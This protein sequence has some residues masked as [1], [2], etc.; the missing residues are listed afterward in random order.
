MNL[1]EFLISPQ[2]TARRE[3]PHINIVMSSR[4]RLARNIRGAAFPGWAKKADRVKSYEIIRPAVEAMQ[5]M[6][7]GFSEAIDSLSSLDKQLLVERHLISR[8]QAAKNAGSGLVLNKD[9]SLCVM[10]NEE[11]HLRMQSLRP[12]LQL[13]EAWTAISGVSMIS[14]DST[15]AFNVCLQWF[16]IQKKNRLAIAVV[17]QSVRHPHKLRPCPRCGIGTDGDRV[18]EKLQHLVL[19]L[20]CYKKP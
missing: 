4:V 14:G 19:L 17:A 6:V 13:K 20:T 8:E 5:Q 9:E 3:G 7:S 15:S 12:G 16:E 2:E 10:I 1:D 18:P 11:D